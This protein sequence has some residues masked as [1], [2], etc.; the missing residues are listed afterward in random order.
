M[1]FSA[2]Y[3]VYLDGRWRP[4]D[5][6]HGK[7]RVGRVLMA[8]GREATDVALVTSF[9]RQRL[10]KFTVVTDEIVAPPAAAPELPL[11]LSA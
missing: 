5:A 3:E 8:R 11:A 2:F 1:D 4:M 10:T 7:T 9:G 6:R